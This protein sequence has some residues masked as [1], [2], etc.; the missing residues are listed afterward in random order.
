VEGMTGAFQT[1]MTDNICLVINSD[2]SGEGTRPALSPSYVSGLTDLL[3]A[4]RL[5]PDKAPCAVI[6]SG[7][8]ASSSTKSLGWFSDGTELGL[9]S[10]PS[11]SLC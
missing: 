10:L 7:A 9:L 8:E 3:Q 4:F 6:L 11:D 5:E 1:T 2:A